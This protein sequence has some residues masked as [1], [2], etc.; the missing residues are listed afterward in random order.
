MWDS[1]LS[2][3]TSLCLKY[4]VYSYI[5]YKIVDQFRRQSVHA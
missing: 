4:L 2:R 3:Y 1:Y 5:D